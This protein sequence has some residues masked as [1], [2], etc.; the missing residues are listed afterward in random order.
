MFFEAVGELL[1]GAFK[2]GAAVLAL[3][4]VYELVQDARANKAAATLAA[5][6]WYARWYAR[7]YAHRYAIYCEGRA[8]CAAIQERQE[9]EGGCGHLTKG[10]VC[11]D[12][13]NS[14]GSGPGCGTNYWKE[15]ASTLTSD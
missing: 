1:G 13:W 11:S 7:W 6:P 14:D 4:V 9:R 8:R 5:K 10:Q 12:C 15:R 3:C 2:G